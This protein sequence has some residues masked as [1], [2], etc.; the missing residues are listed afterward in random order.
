MATGLND[1]NEEFHYSH[2][3]SESS[4]PHC[5]MTP[6]TSRIGSVCYLNALPLIYG[7]E[8]RIQTFVPSELAQNLRNGN[9]DV[10][11]I[12]IAEY[13]ENPQ[14]LIIPHIAIGCR[15]EVLSV[16][17]ASR[18]PV[19]Q[20]QSLALDPASRTSNLLAQILLKE[21]VNISPQVL[22]RKPSPSIP[23]E[24]DAEIWIGDPALQNRQKLLAEGWTLWDLGKA[25]TDH[26]QLPFV[27]AAWAVRR[28]VSHR[29]FVNQLVE[30]KTGGLKNLDSISRKQTT[31]DHATAF[32]YLSHHVSY[33]LEEDQLKG[34]MEFQ[35]LCVRHGLI[36]RIS[37]INLAE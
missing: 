14:Y 22:L 12:P 3:H 28:G 24:T 32:D 11:L 35:R 26:T 1:Q 19:S 17:L 33:D 31:V 15:G 29:P 16:F 13:F 9:L 4:I 8:D 2:L 20:I 5:L 7:M 36:P 25:W 10:G 18:K 21:W 37:E 6:P 27:F 34:W 30:A 23:S